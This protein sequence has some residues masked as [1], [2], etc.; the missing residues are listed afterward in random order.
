MTISREDAFRLASAYSQ[1]QQTQAPGRFSERLGRNHTPS[2]GEV[3]ASS[4]VGR[5][6]LV[7]GL[8]L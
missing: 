2:I 1:D 4:E 7:Y 3:L 6:P 5:P 8:V